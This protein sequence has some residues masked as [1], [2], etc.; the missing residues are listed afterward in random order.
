M[1]CDD[2]FADTAPVGSLL[3]NAWGL[4]DMTGNVWEWVHDWYGIEYYS[5]SPEA[6]PQGPATGTH[7]VK[8]GGSWYD[9]DFNWLPHRIGDL[10]DYRIGNVLGFR[11]V[12]SVQ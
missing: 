5:R 9:S 11:L 8:R 7:H 10:P 2:G 6:D 4:Y 3:H 12:R 1:P